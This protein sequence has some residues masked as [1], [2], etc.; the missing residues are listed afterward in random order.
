MEVA[1]MAE[2]LTKIINYINDNL[3]FGTSVNT[4][5]I[6]WLLQKYPISSHEKNIVYDEL[7]SLSI[8]IVPSYKSLQVKV[9]KLFNSIGKT[10]KITEMAFRTWCLQENISSDTE[11]KV[12]DE[13]R[14][15]G[16]II[17]EDN[18]VEEDTESYDFLDDLDLEDFT[19]LDSE[20]EDDQFQDELSKLKN[21]VDKSHNLEYLRD[22]HG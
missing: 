4:E 1:G 21:V 14:V 5:K 15:L 17:I 13:L 7:T 16:Y 10:K 18:Y 12:R 11:A 9:E 2:N 19:D 20:L 8:K 22:L 3:K 6:D